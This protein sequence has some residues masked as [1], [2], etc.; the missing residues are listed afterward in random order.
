MRE[1]SRIEAKSDNERGA[2]GAQRT[3][4][5]S[6]AAKKYASDVMPCVFLAV[7]APVDIGLVQSLSHPGGNMTGT[8]F[9]AATETYAKRLQILT[10]ILPNLQRVAVLRTIGD[11]NVTFAMRSVEQAAPKLNVNLQLV[12]IKTADDLPRDGRCVADYWF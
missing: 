7:G 4:I 8:T 11:P 3:T 10:E 6:I 2:K 12:D 1:N 5:G 9:E